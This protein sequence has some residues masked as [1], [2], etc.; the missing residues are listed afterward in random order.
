[1]PPVQ[2]TQI[3]TLDGFV[4]REYSTPGNFMPTPRFKASDS[5]SVR[6]LSGADS[7]RA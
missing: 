2:G 5:L 1:M 3:E 6:G 7:Y 4:L